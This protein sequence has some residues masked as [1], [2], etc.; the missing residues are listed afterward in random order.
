L[1]IGRGHPGQ[2]LRLVIGGLAGV[3][4][5]TIAYD[6]IG[7][8]VTPMAATGDA[9]STTWPTR[10]LARLLVAIGAAVAID[11]T[12]RATEGPR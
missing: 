3:I 6:A 11:L 4:V 8:A 9:I 10:L 7:G 2:T 12:I 5:A 1:G